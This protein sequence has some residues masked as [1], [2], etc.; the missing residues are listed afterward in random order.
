MQWIVCGSNKFS[1]LSAKS[2]SKNT[3]GVPIVNPPVIIS[4]IDISKFTSISNSGCHTVVTTSDGEAMGIGYNSDCRISGS[5]PKKVLTKFTKIDIRDREGKKCQVISATCSFDY[6]IYQILSEKG[7]RV[8]LAFASNKIKNKFPVILNIGN[9]IPVTLFNGRANSAAISTKGSFIIIPETAGESPEKLLEEKFL[10]S[11]EKAVS[12][13]FYDG[14]NEYFVY[15][16]SDSGRVYSGGTLFCKLV[17][18][19]K[20][21]TIDQI[22]G[23]YDHCFAVSTDGRVFGRGHNESCRLGIGKHRENFKKFILISTLSKY[24]IRSAYAGIYHS[25]F[26]TYDGKILA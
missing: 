7:D 19:L 22:S 6:T 10:P 21:I 16:L 26:Q 2:N 9:A 8:D 24:K 4:D 17:D 13:A 3:K 25:I 1:Q 11:G 20:D 15:V 23:I 5:L 18:E 14:F 12:V